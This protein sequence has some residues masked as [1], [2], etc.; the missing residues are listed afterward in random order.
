[1]EKISV[2]TLT[3]LIFATVSLFTLAMV[4]IAFLAESLPWIG[5]PLLVLVFIFLSYIPA[6]I[7]KL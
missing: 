3:L 5:I 7:F 6:K 2:I 1:M 4:G